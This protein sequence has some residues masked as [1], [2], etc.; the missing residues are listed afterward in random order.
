MRDD[1]IPYRLTHFYDL[2]GS[3]AGMSLE[4]AA[5]RPCVGLVVLVHI[6]QNEGPSVGW[7]M[8]RMSAPALTDHKFLS[9]A[10][11]SRWDW[12][13][14]NAGLTCMSKTVVFTTFCRKR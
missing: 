10:L 2:D 7:T 3:C 14:G 6:A 9:L 13:P 1:D 4:P 5:L 11:S 8:T 12:S